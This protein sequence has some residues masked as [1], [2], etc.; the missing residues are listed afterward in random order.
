MV[1]PEELRMWK[2]DTGPHSW[3]AHQRNDFSEP[4]PSDLPIHRN[5]LNSLIWDVWLS[6]ISS[7]L[8]LLLPVFCYKTS[9]Y[10]SSP[11]ASSEQ[12]SQGY[13]RYFLPGLISQFCPP[14]EVECSTFRL[15]IFFLGGGQQFLEMYCA[16]ARRKLLSGSSRHSCFF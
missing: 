10:L 13:F 9:I 15:W 7:N 16:V 11:F 6:F 2:Q 5:A 3:G 8:K 14:N 12:F 1:R 4:R